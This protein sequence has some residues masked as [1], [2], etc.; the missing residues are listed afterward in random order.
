MASRRCAP[1]II[2]LLWF[3]CCGVIV[4]RGWC[5]DEGKLCSPQKKP[6]LFFDGIKLQT[7]NCN[8]KLTNANHL[9]HAINRATGSNLDDWDSLLIQSLDLV[10]WRDISKYL[11]T[12]VAIAGSTGSLLSSSTACR[13][14]PYDASLR[15]RQR[16]S[17]LEVW[18][19]LYF[20][21]LTTNCRDE[22]RSGYVVE[23][24]VAV[25]L[26]YTWFRSESVFK[27]RKGNYFYDRVRTNW[28]SGEWGYKMMTGFNVNL[29]NLSPRMNRWIVT[30]SAF[31]IW[32][33]LKGLAAV[34]L[35]D[36]LKINGRRVR[37]DLRARQRMDIDLTG[38]YFSVAVGRYF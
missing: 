33:R 13:T 25:G 7:S 16:Y 27:L 8:P 36:G 20:Y 35:T 14:K 26:G 34:H 6:V 15:M 3:L 21:P 38:P 18:S 22:Y 23:P 11:K 17:A 19:N 28:N 4:P 31:Q 29:G 1:V 10:L 9:I 24:F 37:T 2:I 32:N 30:V 12:D 5:G